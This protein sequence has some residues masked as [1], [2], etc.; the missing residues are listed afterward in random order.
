MPKKKTEPDAATVERFERAL[1]NAL[2]TP[3]E[4]PRKKSKRKKKAKGR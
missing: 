4:T 3:P 2:N 1:R